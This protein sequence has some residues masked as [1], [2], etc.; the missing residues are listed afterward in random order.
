MRFFASFLFVTL[1][2]PSVAAAASFDPPKRKSGLWN[3]G[4]KRRQ[5]GPTIRNVSTKTDDLM[6]RHARR[7]TAARTRY[8]RYKIVIDGKVNGMAKPTSHRPL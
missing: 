4:L 7:E 1:L 3:Q 2:V 8:E 5:G 6:T